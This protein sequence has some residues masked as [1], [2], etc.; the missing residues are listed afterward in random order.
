MIRVLLVDDE[1]AVLAGLRRMLHRKR[2]WQL[3]LA[4]SGEA[5]I[6]LLQSTEVDVVVSDCRMPGMD[7]LALLAHVHEHHPRMAR[8]MLSGQVGEAT[9]LGALD[10]AQQFVAKPCEPEELCDAIERVV[11]ARREIGDGDTLAIV[12]SLQS[13]PSPPSILHELT[14]LLRLDD[15][16]IGDIAGVVSRDVALSAKI[17]QLANSA[18]F[19]VAHEVTSIQG[20]T[21]YLGLDV[22]RGLAAAVGVFREFAGLGGQADL[23]GRL[24]THSLGVA[25][26]A[27]ARLSMHVESAH[28]FTAGML[29]D[30]G[31]LVIGARMPGALAD[32]LD[33]DG[34]T[35]SLDAERERFG[36]TH[37]EVGAA[38]MSLWGL[39]SGI[40]EVAARHHDD[41]WGT[42]HDPALAAIR[43]CEA[44]AAAS[45]YAFPV[46]R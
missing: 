30:I 20:A 22:V 13:L 45:E 39:P 31:W 7:G 23:L 29:H 6:K 1:P 11:S 19:S 26:T 24:E 14:L 17:L 44:E 35:W 21:T 43:D 36:A 34:G 10:V 18:F 3:H 40:V 5:A 42:E 8:I 27:A 9:S 25:S 37:A 46:K 38:L 28:V 16:S 15:V 4:E 2:D 32:Y 33:A 12:A 41:A